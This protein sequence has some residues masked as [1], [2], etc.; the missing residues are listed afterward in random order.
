MFQSSVCYLGAVRQIHMAKGE[1]LGFVSFK[2]KVINIRA[3]L[4]VKICKLDTALQD[5]IYA[6][7]CD[8]QAF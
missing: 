7:L 5:I 2:L 1:V 6:T 3:N 8:A 4:H